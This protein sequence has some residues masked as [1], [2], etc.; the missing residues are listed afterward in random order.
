MELA[1]LVKFARGD[2][3]AEIL[4]KNGRVVNVYTGEIYPADIALAH[5]RIVGIGSGYTANTVYDVGERFV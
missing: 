1:Q 4:I 3:P 5:S 2:E